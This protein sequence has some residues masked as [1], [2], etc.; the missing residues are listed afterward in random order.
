MNLFLCLGNELGFL[1][2]VVDFR[3]CFVCVVYYFAKLRWGLIETAGPRCWDYCC[4]LSYII[5][6]NF[7]Y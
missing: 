1:V 7:I 6:L 4:Q 5:V 3:V 2:L